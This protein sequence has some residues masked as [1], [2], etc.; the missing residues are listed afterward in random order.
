MDVR[1]MNDNEYTFIQPKIIYDI[2]ATT[3]KK[4]YKGKGVGWETNPKAQG[5]PLPAWPPRGKGEGWKERKKDRE[6]EEPIA[7]ALSYKQL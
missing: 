7:A 1:T 2:K 3:N 5:A 4:R 6:K